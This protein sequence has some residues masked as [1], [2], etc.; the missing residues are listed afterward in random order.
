MLVPFPSGNL[1]PRPLPAAPDSRHRVS[2]QDAPALPIR[3]VVHEDRPLRKAL[4]ILKEQIRR[5]PIDDRL[6][7]GHERD[8]NSHHTGLKLRAD[9]K[10]WSFP[11]AYPFGQEAAVSLEAMLGASGVTVV[12]LGR[13]R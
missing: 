8:E 13:G 2:R 5:Q 11:A 4:A 1:L 6:P 7:N 10:E 3:V 9:G 12:D